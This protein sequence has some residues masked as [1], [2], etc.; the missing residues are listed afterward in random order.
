MI[1]IRVDEDGVISLT[2][3]GLPLNPV[4]LESSQGR[5]RRGVTRDGGA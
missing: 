1:E 3:D 2:N 4:D 5:F